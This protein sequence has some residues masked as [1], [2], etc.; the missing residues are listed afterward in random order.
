MQKE[1]MR[2]GMTI[3]IGSR[4]AQDFH[5]WDAVGKKAKV[6]SLMYNAAIVQLQEPGHEE[7]FIQYVDCLLVAETNKAAKPL[8][9]KDY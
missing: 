7:W 4:R 6:T 9:D 1:N 8:L 3:E 5:Y 2:E